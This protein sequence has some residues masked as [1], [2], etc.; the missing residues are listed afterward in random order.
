MAVHCVAGVNR[1]GALAVAYVAQSRRW[2]LLRALRH[3]CR[4][5]GPLVWNATFQR[6]LVRF[7]K[8]EGLL[9]VNGDDGAAAEK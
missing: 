2:P 8:K 7:C 1:S 9:I 6:Q 3:C 4:A 5:R